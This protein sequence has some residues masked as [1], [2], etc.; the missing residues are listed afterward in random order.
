M[1]TSK[2]QHKARKAGVEAKVAA[3]YKDGKGKARVA[4]SRAEAQIR[5]K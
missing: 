1:N 4:R 2:K 5:A 3:R